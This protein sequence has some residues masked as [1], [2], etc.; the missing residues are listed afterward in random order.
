MVLRAGDTITEMVRPRRFEVGL[1]LHEGGGGRS[2]AGVDWRVVAGRKAGRKAEQEVTHGRRRRL[3]KR[4]GGGDARTASTCSGPAPS[5]LGSPRHLAWVDGW[6]HDP[7]AQ[8][9][10]RT[11]R[12]GR[13]SRCTCARGRVRASG[14]G[15]VHT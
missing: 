3:I 1:G 10:N 7:I 15:L 8:S 14:R 9:P 11:A 12:Q 13:L 5:R 6:D 2:G 4:A